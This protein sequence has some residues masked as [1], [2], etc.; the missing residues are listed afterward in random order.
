MPT[1]NKR[2]A[3]YLPP[4]INEKLQNFKSERGIDGDSQALIVALSEF[5]GVSQHAAHS[6]DYSESYVTIEQFNELVSTLSTRESVASPGGLDSELLSKLQSLELRVEVLESLKSKKSTLSTGELAKRLGMNS[7]TLSH[8][9]G[10]NPERSKSP[11][12]LLRA[13]REKDPD[14]I[15]WVLI[16][17]TNRFK[18]EKDLPNEHRDTLQGELLGESDSVIPEF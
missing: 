2:I 13:T 6:V 1:K 18:P 5:L 7:S 12:E 9:K 4:A 8:W 16:P 3:T 15:G 11:D 17:E 10:S 14:G